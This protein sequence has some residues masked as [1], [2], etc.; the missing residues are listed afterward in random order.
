NL[1]QRQQW[2]ARER[3][4]LLGAPLR[5]K[6]ALSLRDGDM[7]VKVRGANAVAN[8]SFGSGGRGGPRGSGVLSCFGNSKKSSKASSSLRARGGRGR[9]SKRKKFAETCRRATAAKLLIESDV[10]LG[11][12]E[13]SF[14]PFA[15]LLQSLA[16]QAARQEERRCR[17]AGVVEMKNPAREKRGHQQEEDVTSKRQEPLAVPK[18][19]SR[20]STP[21]IHE[22][23]SEMAQRKGAGQEDYRSNDDIEV[24]CGHGSNEDKDDVNIVSVSSVSAS[25]NKVCNEDDIMIIDKNC[26]SDDDVSTT[27]SKKAASRKNTETGEQVLE[28]EEQTGQL[29]DV[30]AVSFTTSLSSDFEDSSASDRELH[31][32]PSWIR[33]SKQWKKQE[34]IATCA[35]SGSPKNTGGDMLS[36][37]S[38]AG[39]S[40]K[41][42]LVHALLSELWALVTDPAEFQARLLLRQFRLVEQHAST[43]SGKELF[44]DR[45]VVQTAISGVKERILLS[46]DGIR[47]HYKKRM[48]ELMQV[49]VE[50]CSGPAS[51]SSSRENE[52][53]EGKS[54][55]AATIIDREVYPELLALTDFELQLDLMRDKRARELS[56]N[57]V[58]EEERQ[59]QEEEAWLADIGECP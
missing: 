52:H 53:N 55:V 3:R 44:I 8:S 21:R 25:S 49:V 28:T 42:S 2:R 43:S 18:R 40:S 10:L 50:K 32:A 37:T 41:L 9:P 1:K 34:E 22:E 48:R 11:R 26:S 20:P 57:K 45:G 35:S 46:V 58:L 16:D 6:L 47:E 59:D 39:T 23:E 54:S 27:V 5:V 7:F 38:G 4:R 17:K 31:D 56:S 30:A 24:D 14:A 33:K 12:Q 29:S 13:A 51:S 15:D 36:T 19:R